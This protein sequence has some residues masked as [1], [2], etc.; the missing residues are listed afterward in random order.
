MPGVLLLKEGTGMK[1]NASGN[2]MSSY[3]YGPADLLGIRKGSSTMWLTLQDSAGKWAQ[4]VYRGCVYWR[5]SEAQLGS[6]FSLVQKLSAD[7][8]LQPCHAV[9]LRALEENTF[10]VDKLIREWEEAGLS[11]FLH[12][13]SRAGSEF[14]VA[15]E[16]MEYIELN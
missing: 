6:H 15:A 9:T 11:F 12:F 5:L 10:H 3:C 7:E 13:S 16:S 14:L 4:A 2:L 8:L 1:A